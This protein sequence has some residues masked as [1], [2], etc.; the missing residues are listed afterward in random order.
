MSLTWI[1][2]MPEMEPDVRLGYHTRVDP[3][4]VIGRIFHTESFFCITSS[5]M[6]LIFY[7][8][9]LEFIK[10]SWLSKLAFAK[11]QSLKI[12][13]CN[14]WW[15]NGESPTWVMVIFI[16]ISS[17]SYWSYL[18]SKSLFT[19]SMWVRVRK[20]LLETTMIMTQVYWGSLFI[21]RTSPL[22]SQ[23]IIPTLHII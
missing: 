20:I 19:K 9:S 22:W 17:Y 8:Y 16:L 11:T 13:M 7:M 18:T 5:K 4:N 12:W 23:N 1:L 15:Y 21:A 6:F 2:W 3:L 14:T 10:P